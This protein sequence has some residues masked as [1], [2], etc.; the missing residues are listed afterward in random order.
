M[1][2]G[3]KRMCVLGEL[4]RRFVALPDLPTLLERIEVAEQPVPSI[5]EDEGL[6]RMDT[7]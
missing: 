4:N 6:I 2:K 7:S 5:L 3:N 1:D